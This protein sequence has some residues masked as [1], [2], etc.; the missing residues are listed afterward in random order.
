MEIHKLLADLPVHELKG[1]R[2]T[3]LTDFETVHVWLDD[4][5]GSG[6][7]HLLVWMG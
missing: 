2:A 3:L 4:H 6:R 7:E 1:S 5:E